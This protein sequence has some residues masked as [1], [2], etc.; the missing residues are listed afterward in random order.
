MIKTAKY[1]PLQKPIWDEFIENSKNGTFMLKRDYMDYHADR[2]KDFSLMFYE[3]DKLIAV[4]PASVHGDEIR[5]HGGLTY[6]GI[7]SNKKMTAQKMLDVL[8][9]LT[10]FLKEQKIKH[11]LY[12]RIPSVY[13]V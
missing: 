13:H 5:S 6:G 9:S 12:K 7:V 10:A 1:Y 11:L 3:D 8:D 4:M 2:F